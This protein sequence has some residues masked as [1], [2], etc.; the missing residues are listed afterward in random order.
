MIYPFPHIPEGAI[1]MASLYACLGE[2]LW[3]DL[4]SFNILAR[5]TK[6]KRQDITQMVHLANASGQLK[7]L[8]GVRIT[9]EED[10][11]HCHLQ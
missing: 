3:H 9:G 1:T 7:G 4:F 6:H 10:W 5:D 2:V 11:Q 8:D